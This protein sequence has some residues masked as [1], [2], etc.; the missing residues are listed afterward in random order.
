MPALDE[1]ETLL[2]EI[3]CVLKFYLMLIQ[4]DFESDIESMTELALSN[5]GSRI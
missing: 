1:L 3:E 5:V 2:K 4:T